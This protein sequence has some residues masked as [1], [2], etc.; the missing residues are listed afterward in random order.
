MKT[1]RRRLIGGVIL[2]LVMGGAG[3]LVN[4]LSPG[5]A[6][7]A[8][9]A[10][11]S[12]VNKSIV[13]ADTDFAVRLL[14]ELQA[15]QGG[16]NIFISP[17]SVSIALTMTYNGANSTTR[18]AMTNALGL[19]GMSDDTVNSGYNQLIESL[20][21]ADGDVALNIADSVWIRSTFAPSVKQ[22]FTDTLS[23]SYLSEVYTSPFDPS[24]VGDVNSWVGKET[25][26]RIT[27]IL[28]SID[29]GNVMFLINAIYFK[30]SWVDKF[31]ASLTRPADFTTGGGAAV[32]VQMMNRVGEYA[33]YGDDE[34]QVARLPYGRDKIAMYVFLPAENSTLESFTGGLTGEKLDAYFSRLSE[35][36]LD[37]KLPRLQLDYGKV[38]LKDAL[39]GLG[40]GVAFDPNA[41][42]FSGIADVAPQRLYIAFVDHKA[43]VEVNESGTEAAAV[44]NVGITVTAMPVTTSFNVDRPYL[45]VIRDDRSGAILFSGLITDPTQQTSP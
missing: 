4:Y 45:F 11:A 41:A 2:L 28:D 19:S 6:Y 15:E 10:K 38:D 43:V 24:T 27:R 44:T 31:D 17:L 32:Q 26:G 35:T 42:N 23:K 18:E 1:N 13:A 8:S 37:M 36:E 3:L 39:T 34:V 7:A 40:M 21:N 12:G 29:P 5:W 20:T 14:R 25:D 22:N 9:D 16:K 33:Y 30:G